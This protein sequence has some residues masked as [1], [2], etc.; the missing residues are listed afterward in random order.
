MKLKSTSIIIGGILLWL[1]LFYSACSWVS[2]KNAPKTDFD[3][4]AYQQKRDAPLNAREFVKR[5]LKAPSTA[6]F[7]PT[8]TADVSKTTEGTYIISSYVDSQNGF[9]AMLRK[10]WVVELKY[11]E[12]GKIQLVNI[13]FVD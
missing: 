4:V 10:K 3:E 12:D 6:K 9:G 5:N 8:S 2:D 13:T 11:L 1:F 7:P